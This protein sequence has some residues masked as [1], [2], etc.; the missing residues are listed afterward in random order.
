MKAHLTILGSG[1]CVSSFYKPFDYLAP[2]AYLLQYNGKNYLFD[3]SEGVRARLD[4]VQF[5]YF[6]L[7]YIFIT[8]FHPD[9]FNLDTLLQAIYVRSS[10]KP[11]KKT[12]N[13]YG[14][15][16]IKENLKIIWE[17]KHGKGLFDHLL[18]TVD[19]NFFEYEDNKPIVV[20]NNVKMT[21]F[22]VTHVKSLTCYALQFKLDNKILTY[23]GDSG[24][25]QDIKEASKNADIFISECN[26]L[27]EGKIVPWHLRVDEVAQIATDSN[28]KTVI[29]THLRGKNTESE[30]VAAIK[31]SGFLGPV[32]VASDLKKID[33]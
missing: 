5:D 33:F 23:S 6:N 13:I 31:K 2:S 12:I 1:T 10:Y 20:E 22:L 29:L 15:K 14:P 8:H 24:M 30:L 17:I 3:C 25:C 18:Q 9:H 26:T 7:D 16:D 4:S 19:L 32:I 21:P 28:V 11:V 27:I